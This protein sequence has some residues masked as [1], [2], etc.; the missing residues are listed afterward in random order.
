MSASEPADLQAQLLAMPPVAAMAVRV[1][2]L[3][4]ERV[5]LFAPLAANINDKGCAFGGSIAGLLTLAGWSLL[6]LRLARAGVT[7]DVFVADS[8]IEYLAPLYADLYAEAWLA[9]AVDWDGALARLHERGRASVSLESI[10]HG[11]D[12]VAAARMHSRFAIRRTAP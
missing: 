6:V 8:R 1:H 11:G 12:G 3:D 7:A 4:A 5:T 2:A 9:A 10:L